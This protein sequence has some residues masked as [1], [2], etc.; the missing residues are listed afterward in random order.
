MM[1]EEIMN[2]MLTRL[3]L[4][5]WLPHACAADVRALL[6]A[7]C[8][9]RRQRLRVNALIESTRRPSLRRLASRCRRGP[10]DDITAADLPDR[11]VERLRGGACASCASARSTIRRAA[12]RRAHLHALEAALGRAS[13][14]H[15][16]VRGY[17]ETTAVAR[18][19]CAPPS[20]PRLTRERATS[21]A[22]AHSAA[23][24]TR[25]ADVVQLVSH[26]SRMPRR[27]A[28]LER[29][30][31]ASRRG[32]PAITRAR[33]RIRQGRRRAGEMTTSTHCSPRIGGLTT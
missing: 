2:D 15:A 24:P 20:P 32:S 18:R 30:K 29:K 5:A 1:N 14:G 8:Q 21:A 19:V 28:S 26:G 25:D 4:R 31:A 22:G 17:Y 23:R 12:A 3:H 9:R 16:G 13:A 7:R 11:V 10:A 27:A 33:C 6:T